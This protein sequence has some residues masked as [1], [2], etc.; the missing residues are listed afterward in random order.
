VRQ[1]R[2]LVTRQIMVCRPIC[3]RICRPI[4]RRI[5]RWVPRAPRLNPGWQ[6]A[7]L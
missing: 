1:I 7:A 4:C 6:P 3:R 5:C 2:P